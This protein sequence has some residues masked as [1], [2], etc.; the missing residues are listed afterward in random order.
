MNKKFTSVYSLIKLF[1]IISVFIFFS[2]GGENAVS[3]FSF[4]L[5]DKAAQNIH[6]A[7]RNLTGS[8]D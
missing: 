6:N 8:D 3:S 5:G 4:Q 2:C 7:A 1:S